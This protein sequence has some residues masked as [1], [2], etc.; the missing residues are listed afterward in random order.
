M[1]NR[2]LKLV[3]SSSEVFRPSIYRR[4]LTNQLHTNLIQSLRYSSTN[5]QLYPELSSKYLESIKSNQEKRQENDYDWQKRTN[6]DGK[7]KQQ[8]SSNIGMWKCAALITGSAILGGKLQD[9]K[10]DFYGRIL[11]DLTINACHCDGHL[12]DDYPD[13]MVILNDPNNVSS[14][15][16]DDA[17][18][19]QFGGPPQDEPPTPNLYNRTMKMRQYTKVDKN[20]D[21][22][23]GKDFMNWVKAVAMLR[24]YMDHY[25]YPI[26]TYFVSEIYYGLDHSRTHAWDYHIAN[27]MRE[28]ELNDIFRNISDKNLRVSDPW[29]PVYPDHGKLKKRF[30]NIYTDKSSWGNPNFVGERTVAQLFFV[31]PNIDWH[32]NLEIRSCE[33]LDMLD[34][35]SFQNFARIYKLMKPDTFD[36]LIKI[37]NYIMHAGGQRLSDKQLSEILEMFNQSLFQKPS[38]G[39]HEWRESVYLLIE[40]VFFSDL[41][42]SFTPAYYP[43]DVDLHQF[44]QNKLSDTEIRRVFGRRRKDNQ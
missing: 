14:L 44:N 21:T 26:V 39:L 35:K 30:L 43:L 12:S 10:L 16:I 37:R 38:A 9:H 22:N 1:A 29:H 31:S 7:S 23:V 13:D 18:D 15:D 3:N 5:P 8:K 2:W 25:V 11:S 40:Q 36:D 17:K 24:C 41:K 19:E 33:W 6:E 28:K 27:R 34:V 32:K 20:A 42:I 4:G